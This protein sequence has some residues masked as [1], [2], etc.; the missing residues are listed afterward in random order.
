MLIDVKGWILVEL[1]ERKRAILSA[2]I[3]AYTQHGEPIGSKALCDMLDFTLSSATLRNEMS[4]LC[5]LGYLEQPHTSAGRIPT[6]L[7]YKL[8][9]DNLMKRDAVSGDMK[10]IIDSMLSNVSGGVDDIA[11]SASQILSELTGMPVI[12]SR[13]ADLSDKIKRVAFMPLGL[14]SLLIVLMTENGIVKSTSLRCDIGANPQITEQLRNLCEEHIVGKPLSTLTK[15]YLQQMLTFAD[16]ISIISLVAPLF[17]LIEDAKSSKIMLRG[18][19]KLFRCCNHDGEVFRLFETLSQKELMLSLLS[20]V[21]SPVGVLF[22][23][24]T[25]INELKPTTIVLA[26]YGSG[27]HTLGQIGIIGPTR[28]SYDR[29]IPS[30]EYFAEKMS[31]VISESLL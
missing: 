2:I 21:D 6:V 16:D 23:N 3:G 30:L 5:E 29:L 19:S 26:K 9:I 14:R 31:E 10:L 27:G 7:A 22:G 8:Y 17:E 13:V 20:S 11:L 12:T 24:D 4:D 25:D 15:T 1:N 18:E 28:M